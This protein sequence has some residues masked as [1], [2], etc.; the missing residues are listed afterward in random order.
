MATTD[1]RLR[2]EDDF[3]ALVAA[4]EDVYST[5]GY[6]VQGTADAAAFFNPDGLVEAWVAVH[7]EVVVGHVAIIAAAKGYQPAVRALLDLPG[8]GADVKQCV[9]V[10]RFFVRKYARGLGLGRTLIERT[11]E[12]ARENKVKIVMNVLSK[13]KA[14]IQLYEKVD[15]RR[16]GEGSYKNPAGN[17]FPESFYVYG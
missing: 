16:I 1:I 13:D 5:D 6:P 15:F 8:S 9:V 2:T 12:W 4:L 17:L 3:A 10:A 7:D 11:C 14:A